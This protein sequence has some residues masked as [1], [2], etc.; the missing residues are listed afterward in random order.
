[1]HTRHRL[2]RWATGAALA[3][4]IGLFASFGSGCCAADKKRSI[5]Q[6]QGRDHCCP[7]PRAGCFQGTRGQGLNRWAKLL[8]P[9]TCRN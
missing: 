8:P 4:L 3:A 7:R 9:A 1:M 6:G 5:K 2:I